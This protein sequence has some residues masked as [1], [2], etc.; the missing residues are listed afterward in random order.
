MSR[1]QEDP[2][3]IPHILYDV[4]N[5]TRY[6]RQRFFGKVSKCAF[7]FFLRFAYYLLLLLLSNALF[8]NGV[9]GVDFY[10]KDTNLPI[11]AES[12]ILDYLFKRHALSS[13]VWLFRTAFV[14]I[15]CVFV[16]GPVVFVGRKNL[17]Q[18]TRP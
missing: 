16:C 7:F 5:N 4:K 10:E 3:E 11:W 9:I 1:K 15:T 8:R 18:N 13:I 17:S 12:V 2:T 14:M 6:E